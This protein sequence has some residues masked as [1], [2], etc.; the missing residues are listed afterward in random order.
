MSG[1]Q[2]LNVTTKSWDIIASRVYSG[3]NANLTLEASGPT[4]NLLIKTNGNVVVVADPTG[5]VTFT[6]PPICSVLPVVNAHLVNKQYADSFIASGAQGPQGSQGGG[7]ATGSQGFIGAQG[8]TGSK[9]LNGNPGSP[10]TDGGLGAK[11]SQGFIGSQGGLGSQGSQGGTGGPGANGSPGA[12]GDQGLEGDIGPQ[13]PQG[14]D[15]YTGPQG[16]G[17]ATG[18]QATTLTLIAGDNINITQGGIGNQDVVISM[19]QDLAST[20]SSIT[21][22]SFNVK[23]I[24][25]SGT[26][27]VSYSGTYNFTYDG[28]KFVMNDWLKVPLNSGSATPGVAVYGT[29]ST[30]GGVLSSVKSSERYK[31]NIEP[32]PDNDDI[33]NVQPVYFNYKDSSG[34]AMEIKRIG[35]IAEEVD[36]IDLG[37]YF[38][39]KDA[40]GNIETI[41][42]DLI[43]PL[44]SSALRLLKTRL[45]NLTSELE[46]LK[47]N[48]KIK[49]SVYEKRIS[50]L[51]NLKQ[52]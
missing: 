37:K 17:G 24:R 23:N 27:G 45:T 1:N 50:T 28:T 14:P 3:L 43:V 49:I 41:N 38:V 21:S 12:T 44:Y 51:E 39:V 42:Y 8:G 10:G 31:T 2:Q 20:T 19:K 6:K 25:F 52:T 15:G 34:N 30:A 47:E 26:G 35:F 13:G 48:Q 40:S 4:A 32:L 29:T 18:S 9:G 7:G 36:K 46:I 11:G 5:N 33:L 16:G 22:D